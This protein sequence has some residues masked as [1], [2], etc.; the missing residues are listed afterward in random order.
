VSY[1][2]LHIVYTAHASTHTHTRT[3]THTHTY[4]HT[5]T[6]TH[7][8]IYT[9]NHTKHSR[10]CLRILNHIHK[11]PFYVT[12]AYLSPPRLLAFISLQSMMKVASEEHLFSVFFLTT[13]DALW[14][15]DVLS[16]SR[17]IVNRCSSV[18]RSL[19]K[20]WWSLTSPYQ[21][22]L[23]YEIPRHSL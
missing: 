22:G 5:H 7:K 4:A 13:E 20:S 9:H 21:V 14:L 17:N 23:V 12:S 11:M 1:P 10:W 19:P 6:H 16:H 2:K 15:T 18:T 8:Q 3:H